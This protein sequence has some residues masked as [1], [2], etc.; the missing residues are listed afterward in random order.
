MT[1]SPIPV[2]PDNS[3]LCV[4]CGT[5]IEDNVKVRLAGGQLQACQA[6]ETW[7][8]FPRPSQAE[9]SG[10]HDNEE[11]FEHPYFKLRRELNAAQLRRC[12]QVF[13]R[14]S[15]S[16]DPAG[17]RGRRML[18]IGCDTGVFLSAAV[19]Q[20]GIVP[21]GV[22]VNRNAVRVAIRNG[23][24]AYHGTLES[25]P[26]EVSDFPLVTA[27]D[28][29]EHVANPKV[30][31]A[32]IRNRLSPGGVAYLETPNIRSAVYRIGRQLSI[33]TGG[34]PA[35]LYDRLFP[36]QHIQY[37]TRDSLSSLVRS[38]GMEVLELRDRPLATDAIAAAMPIRAAMSVM[39]AIDGMTREHIL[40]WAVIRRP[41]ATAS[42]R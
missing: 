27:V 1:T 26:A 16:V 20:F 11:Y 6:C 2:E 28:L 18:D 8:W 24:E 32:E 35:G 34:R 10:I 40:L 29:V 19:R 14:L 41:A 39:Q 30:L 17:F 31:L 12:A 5:S 36:A 25:A 15:G 23:I 33:L 21:V 9:Q 38:V 7:M 13:Q 37:F 42:L 22:D 4:A 3:P